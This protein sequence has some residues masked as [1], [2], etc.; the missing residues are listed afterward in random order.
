MMT[1]RRQPRL[2]V[3]LRSLNRRRRDMLNLLPET[4]VGSMCHI[5]LLVF[6]RQILGD[7]LLK[8]RT[9]MQNT[10]LICNPVLATFPRLME[11]PD[12]MDALRSG[13]AE[14]ENS[15]KRSEKRDKEFM[16]NT[17]IQVYHDTAYPLLESTFLQT[18]RWAEDETEAARWKAI[19]DF[20]KQNR[21]K[22]GALNF[23]L[24]SDSLHKPFD[25]SQVTYDFLD[26]ARTSVV[27][28]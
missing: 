26:A 13:W 24:S 25:I 12:I 17:F 18:P 27:T 23:L 20:L 14:K 2:L 21:E 28:I 9:S 6:Y 4:L 10:D 8:E 7:V 1:Q 11:Q 5:P 16:K 22:E 19:A 3:K 15:L